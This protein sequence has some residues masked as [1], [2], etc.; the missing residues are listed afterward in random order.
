MEEA[1]QEQ[2]A[3]EGRRRA[4]A[5]QGF[6]QA[7]VDLQSDP[8]GSLDHKRCP[9]QGWFPLEAKQT[10]CTPDLSVIVWGLPRWWGARRWAPPWRGISGLAQATLWSKGQL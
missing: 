10:W 2:G 4:E 8:T 7:G 5:E 3:G 9:P 1:L 6:A